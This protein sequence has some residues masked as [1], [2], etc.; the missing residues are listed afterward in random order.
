[1]MTAMLKIIY[2]A[3]DKDNFFVQIHEVMFNLTHDTHDV[4][5][6]SGRIPGRISVK[7][8]WIAVAM[9]TLHIHVFSTMRIDR[10][11]IL[12]IWG[13][14]YNN[15]QIILIFSICRYSV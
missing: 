13:H 11:V 7:L 10:C 3:S 6:Y 4:P 8:M 15:N 12:S 5:N 1:M 9:T 2:S 14:I